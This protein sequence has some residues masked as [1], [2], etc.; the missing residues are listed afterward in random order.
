[1]AFETI[2]MAILTHPV[3]ALFVGMLF[4]QAVRFGFAK[5]VTRKAPSLR[6]ARAS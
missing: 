6:L 5:L 1:M 3:H 2:T 4:G